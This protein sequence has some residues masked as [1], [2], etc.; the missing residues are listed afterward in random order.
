MLKLKSQV[1]DNRPWKEHLYFV[2]RAQS[3][4][5]QAAKPPLSLNGYLPSDVLCLV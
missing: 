3:E 2:G 1:G 4:I 5:N